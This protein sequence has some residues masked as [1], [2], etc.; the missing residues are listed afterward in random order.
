MAVI[1]GS[2]VTFETVNDAKAA[3]NTL[4]DEGVIYKIKATRKDYNWDPNSTL[5]VDDDLIIKLTD[6]NPGRLV[7]SGYDEWET[8][9]ISSTSPN[10]IAQTS[11]PFMILTFYLGNNSQNINTPIWY[12]PITT[13]AAGMRYFG[14]DGSLASELLNNNWQDIG[15]TGIKVKYQ[16]SALLM[17]KDENVNV[18]VKAIKI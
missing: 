14:T 15:S 4:S 10:I 7:V 5:T 6:V 17:Y 13:Q 2:I 16:N 1:K 8:L 12:W 3:G 11:G 9:S 18:Q